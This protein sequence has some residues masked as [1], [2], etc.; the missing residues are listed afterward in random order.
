MK[1]VC[2]QCGRTSPGGD[3]FCQETYCPGEMSPTI[4][5]AGDWCG[6][7]EIVKPIIVLRSAVLYEAMH[8]KRKV[9][10]K[11]AHPGA[12]NKE[13]LKREAEFL[14]ALQL[15]RQGQPTLPAL[16]PPYA[17]TTVAHDAYGKTMLRGHLLYF[18]LFEHFEGE[19]LR[20]VLVRNPQLWINHVGWTVLS[21][22]A[23]VNY[24][25]LDKRYHYGLGP[26]SL[27][28]R[29]DEKPSAPR[30]LLFDLGIAT[31]KANLALDWYPSFVLPAYTAPELVDATRQ[32]V[33]ADYRTDVYG[34]GLVLYE[35]L[36]GQP[37]FPFRLRSDDEVYQ[38]ITRDQRVT[39]NRV[40]D[41]DKVAQ[42]A[43]KAVSQEPAGRQP[44]AVDVAVQLKAL[45]GDVPPPKRSPWPSLHT[46]FLVVVV[47]LIIGFLIVLAL[48]L[49]GLG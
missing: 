7:I 8:Q 25:H 34:L 5:D 16:L 2:L 33:V 23:T 6:D 24:L 3:L 49:N 27:L 22:A 17:N 20:D 12:E 4:L 32:T 18:F 14:Q 15:R 47:L 42:I 9:Y 28:V 1:Q 13:R 41:V 38:A 29:F 48:S 39:M 30:I 44:S 10:L 21:L 31:D 35:M 40:E 43:L 19:P 11:V 45:F 37:A 26:D 36:V 46:I